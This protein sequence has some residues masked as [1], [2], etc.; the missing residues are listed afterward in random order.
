[1][2]LQKQL[3]QAASQGSKMRGTSFAKAG[4]HSS[5]AFSIYVAGVQK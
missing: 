1:M 3:L 2:Q 4:D 5:P